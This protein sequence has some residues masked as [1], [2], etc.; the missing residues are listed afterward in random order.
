MRTHIV[1]DDQLLAEA[2]KL[3]GLR[4][5]REVVEAS[6]RLMVRM[7]RQERI[8]GASGR[9]TWNGDLEAMRRD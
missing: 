7:M 1:I 2:L 4:T 8:R 6:L 3:A 9:L 5:T